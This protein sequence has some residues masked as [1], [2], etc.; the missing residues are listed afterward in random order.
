MGNAFTIDLGDAPD[1]APFRQTAASSQWLDPQYRR[2]VPSLSGVSFVVEEVK[3]AT[4]GVVIEASVTC[5]RCGGG[6][7][8]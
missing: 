2:D 1:T 8:S 5:V 4:A 7:L 3:E 6:P